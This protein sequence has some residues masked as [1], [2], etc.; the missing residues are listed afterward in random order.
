[1][2]KLVRKVSYRI[3]TFLLYFFATSFMFLRQIVQFHKESR[4]FIF[5]TL[6]ASLISS[7]ATLLKISIG[8]VSEALPREESF[9]KMLYEWQWT[10]LSLDKNVLFQIK[11]SLIPSNNF[12]LYSESLK[13]NSRRNFNDE[14]AEPQNMPLFAFERIEKYLSLE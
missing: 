5:C 7:L 11:C 14:L 6:F 3:R 2:P 9:L 12:R 10:K 13:S 1:M 8:D 4:D